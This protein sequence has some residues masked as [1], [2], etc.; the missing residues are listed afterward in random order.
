MRSVPGP[1][2]RVPSRCRPSPCCLP[3][4]FSLRLTRRG[5]APHGPV[6][7]RRDLSG[8]SHPGSGDVRVKTLPPIE[9]GIGDARGR[10]RPGHARNETRTAASSRVSRTRAAATGRAGT[11]PPNRS[12]T[13]P[14][15][16]P[17]SASSTPWRPA[18]GSR[19]CCR[20]P[21]GRRT[22]LA[23]RRSDAT[24]PSDCPSRFAERRRSAARP[25]PLR[26][27]P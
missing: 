10:T 16:T 27:L 26:N 23:R 15:P 17:P 20:S 25:R 6:G 1:G 14:M 19:S 9:E 4:R 2:E 8:P 24:A 5:P 7:P 3:V 11:G 21:R 13:S 22:V 12:T 18:A